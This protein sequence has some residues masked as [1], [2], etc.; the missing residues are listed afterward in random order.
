MRNQASTCWLARLGCLEPFAYGGLTDPEPGGNLPLGQLPRVGHEAGR[1][2]FG[3]H[4]HL[5]LPAYGFF[6]FLFA[7]TPRR[8]QGRSV[9]DSDAGRALRRRA[10]PP[11]RRNR[12]GR[13][14]TRSSVSALDYRF[15]HG[16]WTAR[17]RVRG[18]VVYARTR[19]ADSV[20][21][22]LRSIET[23]SSRT[24]RVAPRGVRRG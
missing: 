16:Q 8:E 12:Q 24:S 22:I 4:V 1:V 15:V 20:R 19:I 2:S 7:L 23:R 18:W 5:A 21:G 10:R 11:R 13:R 9:L 14:R 6:L 17:P 3:L